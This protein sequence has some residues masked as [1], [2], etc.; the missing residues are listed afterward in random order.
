MTVPAEYHSIAVL[1]IRARPRRTKVVDAGSA[2]APRFLPWLVA[3][4]SSAARR[5]NKVMANISSDAPLVA[6]VTP[7][8]NGAA[9]LRET[10]DSVQAISH[11]NLVHIVLDNASTDA[12]PDIIRAYANA[13]VPV[14]A[15]RNTST[16]SMLANWNAAVA[17]IPETA[18]YFWLLCADDTLAPHAISCALKIAETDRRILLVGC[19]WRAY[20]GQIVGHEL[21]RAKS[22]FEGKEILRSYLRREHAALAGPHML[23]RR[24]LL[25]PPLPYYGDGGGAGGIVVSFDTEANLR[26]C[27]RGLFGFVHDELVHWRQH[28]GSATSMSS[29]KMRLFDADWPLL[30]DRYAA[31]ALGHAEY[32]DCRKSFR[33]RLLRRLLLV[34]LKDG[35]KTTFDWHVNLMRSRDDAARWRDFADALAEWPLLWLT[36]Q[37]A[38]VGRPAARVAAAPAAHGRPSAPPS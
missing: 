16:L 14:L 19:Q 28:P 34:R 12:T 2:V 37:R 8:F 1:Q 38:R 25:N 15:A 30:L 13:R 6:I 18:Q 10:M 33:R 9:F 5:H 4:V 27:V 26:A 23:V 22:I 20:N 11:P 29:L 21:P 7:V 31:H 3:L 36:G 24:C 35:D 32:L 17:L